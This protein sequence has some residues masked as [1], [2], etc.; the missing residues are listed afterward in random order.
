MLAVLNVTFASHALLAMRI[1]QLGV[2]V[3]TALIVARTAVLLW[4]EDAKWITF[5]FTLFLPTLLFFT[6]QILTETFTACGVATFVY[7]LVKEY[8]EPGWTPV[9]GMGFTAGIL[10]LLR[11]NTIF[12]VAV[13]LFAA[14]Q[15]QDTSVKIRRAV[16]PLALAAMIVS[17]WLIRN[18]KVF[19]GGIVY[20]SQ[21]GITALQGVLSPSGRTRPGEPSL[22]RQA[23]WSLA[24]IETDNPRR[25]KF[26]SEDVLN[27]QAK[28]EAFF[29][30][31]KKGIGVLPLIATKLSFFWLSADEVFGTDGFSAGQ[32]L[33]RFAG[34][35]CYWSA[36]TAAVWSWFVLRRDYPRLAAA[37][38]FYCVLATLLHLP[39]TMNTRLRIPLIDP[40]ICLLTG[41]ACA[42][43]FNASGLSEDTPQTIA[44]PPAKSTVT[45][46]QA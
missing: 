11:F 40:V 19:H 46:T 44:A 25:L 16:V 39:F 41:F 13:I 26:A 35:L 34:V 31:K 32:R 33:L 45:L 8:L 6:P 17:P 36:L 4:G 1:I 9:L 23:G 12:I 14:L 18:V 7:Y 24:D 10:L 22:W 27:R 42:Q 30:W 3:A 43:F 38:L 37:I 5:A 15:A 20:S 29:D 28:Q 2:A 21:T